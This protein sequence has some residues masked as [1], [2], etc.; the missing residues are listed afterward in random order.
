MGSTRDEGRPSGRSA[1][2]VRRRRQPAIA[3]TA[4]KNPAA[5][6][7]IVPLG[8]RPQ[9]RE[10]TSPAITDPAP[11]PADHA[12]VP[13]NERASSWALAT[14]R[15]IRAATRRRPTTRIDAT[16]ITAVRTES[17]ALSAATGS[18]AT[19]AHSSSATAANRARR[20]RP[21]ARTMP[22]PSPTTA[23]TSSAVTVRI[24]PN[25]YENRLAFSAP[26]RPRRTTPAAI[27]T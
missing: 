21:N 11:I 23:S 3:A 27:P 16:T 25:R 9:A 17:R 5:T 7:T 14:G 15:T 12:R 13:R 19:R 26:P 8:A 1:A 22:A 18:P 2:P 24:E 10:A 4:A 20:V 6:S